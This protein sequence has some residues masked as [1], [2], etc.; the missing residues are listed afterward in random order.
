MVKAPDNL[1][2]LVDAIQDGDAAATSRLVP[3]VYAELRR[4]AAHYLRVER[5]AHTLQPT[6]LVHEAYIRLMDQ[7]SNA[8]QNRAHFIGIA[9]QVMR[10]ILVEHA[11]ARN[12]EKRG[13]PKCQIT[14]DEALAQAGTQNIDVLALHEALERLAH[15]DV[16]QSRIVEL[17]FFGGLSFDEI[18]LVLD[19]SVRTVK[20]DWKMARAWLYGELSNK[21]NCGEM[22]NIKR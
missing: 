17:H 9:A 20:R 21:D 12:A 11:R 4:L 5:R 16:R 6:A 22:R 10:R 8:W 19:I 13:G 7:R 1:T 14:L 15:S 3:I 2:E 18:A